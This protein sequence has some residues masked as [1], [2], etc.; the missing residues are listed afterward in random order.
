VL[1]HQ[2]KSLACLIGSEQLTVF[3]RGISA[4]VGLC[5]AGVLHAAAL[6][7]SRSDGSRSV[8]RSRL[9]MK[10]TWHMVRCTTVGAAGAEV[11]MR[12]VMEN[13]GQDDH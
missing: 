8:S 10:W 5:C 3:I 2:E 1:T 13:G 6:R 11:Y 4:V 9:F 7:V 12:A